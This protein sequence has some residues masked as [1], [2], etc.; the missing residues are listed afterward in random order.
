MHLPDGIKFTGI[1]VDIEEIHH[2]PEYNMIT[3]ASAEYDFKGGHTDLGFGMA[4]GYCG[5][6]TRSI[7]LVTRLLNLSH[8][9]VPVLLRPY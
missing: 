5:S 7:S 9:R 6:R 3:N 4:R 8:R 1:T 2:L